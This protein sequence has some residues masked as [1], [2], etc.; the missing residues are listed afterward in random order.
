VAGRLRLRV[1]SPAETVADVQG[2][3]WVHVALGQARPLTIWPGHAPLLAE[4]S[5]ESVR[6]ADDRGTHTLSLAPGLLHVRQ[7]EVL[8]LVGGALQG[9]EK[10]GLERYDR[11]TDAL[12]AESG[13]GL[14]AREPAGDGA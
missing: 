10:E 4:T 1:W 9:S 14:A 7:D 2:V 3:H 5:A 8:I 13:P 11:L 6:Y 12:L